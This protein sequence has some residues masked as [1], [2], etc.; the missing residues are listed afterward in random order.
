MNLACP[1]RVIAAIIAIGLAVPAV[2]AP[3]A[4][5][6]DSQLRSDLTL[7]NDAGIAQVMVSQWPV[8]WVGVLAALSDSPTLDAQPRYIREAIRRVR[9]RATRETA[10]GGR[11]ETLIDATNRP[12]LVRG[13]DA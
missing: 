3:W 12:A 13:F 7:L 5:V 4:S 1:R 9:A 10:E 2:A 8:P 6:G 11:A